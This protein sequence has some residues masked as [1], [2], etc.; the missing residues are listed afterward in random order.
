MTSRGVGRRASRTLFVALLAI[1]GL[2]VAL[3]ATAF[4]AT[5]G[6]AGWCSGT[7]GTTEYNYQGK[8]PQIYGPPHLSMGSS[9]VIP[10]QQR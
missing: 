9:T 2:Q 7:D 6:S 4:A 3:P 1:T 5:C 8:Y 10:L